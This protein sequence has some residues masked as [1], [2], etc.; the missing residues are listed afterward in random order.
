[1]SSLKKSGQR[2]FVTGVSSCLLPY[3]AEHVKEQSLDSAWQGE[4]SLPAS[5]GTTEQLSDSV[6]LR[7]EEER[8]GSTKKSKMISYVVRI[9]S[10]SF[11]SWPARSHCH[12]EFI[13]LSLG[14]VSLLYSG[15]QSRIVTVRL[16][17]I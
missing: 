14:P 9:C 16:L 13:S 15:I 1:M 5:L 4:S 3:S 11:S 6:E 17:F 8:L 7:V 12:H 10:I 2:M